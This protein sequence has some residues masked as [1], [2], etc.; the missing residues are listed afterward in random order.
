MRILL[1][2]PHPFY[3]DRGSPIDVDILVRALSRR[4][5]TVDLVVYGEGEDRQYPGVT[6]HRAAT[7]AWLGR[8]RPG[9]SLKKLLVDL[10]FFAKARE[11]VLRHDYDVIHAGEEAVFFAMWFRARRGIPYVYDLDSSIAQQLVEKMPWLKPAGWFFNW[12]EARA[13][14]SALATAP[15]CNALADLARRRGARHVVTLHDIS[16][17]KPGDF[18]CRESIREKLGI[19]GL[20]LMYVGNLEPYQGI[21]LLL[22]AFAR[23]PSIPVPLDLVVAGGTL[24]LI[25]QYSSKASRLGIAEKTHFIGPWPAVRL[26]ELLVQADILTAPRIKGI[27]TP[28]KVFPYLHSGK[29]VLVTDLPTH[30]QILT[31]DVCRLAPAEPDGFARAICALATDPQARQ[32]LGAAGRAFVEKNHTFEAHER[33]VNELYDYV[34]RTAGSISHAT[35]LALNPE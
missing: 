31:Q 9:F 21:D 8:T 13:I 7:P 22:E 34:Q 23:V 17:M 10:W 24:E 14:R 12:C 25:R 5:H 4:G 11:L 16:S 26:G 29:A 2:A 1:L 19:K 28:Q 33:R 20:V 3:I 30:S 35:T 27:N 15:V 18:A 6:I 32:R